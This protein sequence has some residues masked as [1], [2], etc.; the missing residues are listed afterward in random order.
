MSELAELIRDAR[1]PSGDALIGDRWEADTS[2][3]R[4]EQL[5]PP[6]V[7]RSRPWR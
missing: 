4:R 3:G 2:G 6:P 1:L 7:S 5:D